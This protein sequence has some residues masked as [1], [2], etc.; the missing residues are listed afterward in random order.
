[1]L[2][3][4]IK[5]K[6]DIDIEPPKF[7]SVSSDK[8]Q[9]QAGEQILLTVISEDETNVDRVSATFLNDTEYGPNT[10]SSYKTTPD[11]VEGNRY[12]YILTIDIPERTPSTSY[13]LNSLYIYDGDYITMLYDYYGEEL[14]DLVIDIGDGAPVTE[15]ADEFDSDEEIVDQPEQRT[16]PEIIEEVEQPAEPIIEDDLSQS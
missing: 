15:P 4:S 13:S 6:S 12:E 8:K 7:I 11:I 1:N 2:E 16:E 5:G 3:I 10:L 9:Y 14:L